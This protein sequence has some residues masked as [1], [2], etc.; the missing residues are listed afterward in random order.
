MVMED[1]G[2]SPTDIQ[3]LKADARRIRDELNQDP[4]PFT[5][6][7]GKDP[8]EMVIYDHM[9]PCEGG[10]STIGRLRTNISSLPLIAE[11]LSQ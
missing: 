7:E 9:V 5:L 3:S 11:L 2:K 10:R 4:L 8:D 6:T 1:N